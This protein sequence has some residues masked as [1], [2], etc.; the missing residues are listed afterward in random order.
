MCHRP[1][2][3]VTENQVISD[4]CFH[5]FRINAWITNKSGLPFLKKPFTFE[6]WTAW[7]ISLKAEFSAYVPTWVK[8]WALPLP[9]S[10]CFLFI[11]PLSVSVHPLS[12]TWSLP[13]GS[14]SK[15]ISPIRKTQFGNSAVFLRKLTDSVEPYYL[16][17]AGETMVLC[18]NWNPDSPYVSEGS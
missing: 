15:S 12:S 17:I 4:S 5:P 3:P 14:I 18:A 10:G 6:P 11:L 7:S 9:I 2:G 1:S 16:N 8:S 13:S